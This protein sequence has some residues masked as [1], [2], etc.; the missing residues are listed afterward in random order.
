MF[1]FRQLQAFQSF[2][3]I[4]QIRHDFVF[5][6]MKRIRR[7]DS[8]KNLDPEFVRPEPSSKKLWVPGGPIMK[9]TAGATSPGRVVGNLESAVKS[10]L[11]NIK[12]IELECSTTQKLLFNERQK[13]FDL[14]SEVILSDF[15]LCLKYELDSRQWKYC[16][17]NIF[18]A[19]RKNFVLMNQTERDIWNAYFITLNQKYTRFI[20][21]LAKLGLK[22]PVWSRCYSHLGDLARYRFQFLSPQSLN[23]LSEAKSYYHI[24]RTLAPKNGLYYNQ[25]GLVS[26]LEG[27]ITDT[28]H[29]HLRALC[30]ERPLET[31]RETLLEVFQLLSTSEA[32]IVT[33]SSYSFLRT[34]E[35]TFLRL[36]KVLY[37]KIGV[38]DWS[39]LID[40]FTTNLVLGLDALAQMTP[41]KQFQLCFAFAIIPISV[42]QT[43]QISKTFDSNAKSMLQQR[44]FELVMSIVS[45]FAPVCHQEPIKMFIG[46]ILSWLGSNE[47]PL[48]LAADPMFRKNWKIVVDMF[49]KIAPNGFREQSE[50][51]ELKEVYS[52]TE[53]LTEDL[54]VYGFVPF[55]SFVGIEEWKITEGSQMQF[56][57]DSEAIRLKRTARLILLVIYLDQVIS[58]N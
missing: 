53:N 37:T 43:T 48:G 55:S 41:T 46:L 24:A 31:A 32:D 57:S 52:R 17:Y 56:G 2:I 11:E 49:N 39:S 7:K 9:K 8:S 44:C 45:K 27:N 36:I 22:Y 15:S 42:F 4:R 1:L 18:C 6:Q 12:K 30:L 28:I 54:Q 23:L 25:L 10:K 58:S 21:G 34:A 16:V 47:V 26:R 35:L 20:K 3:F 13:L 19:S 33:Y 5:D 40:L 50:A 14:Y 51:M 29:H 38:D